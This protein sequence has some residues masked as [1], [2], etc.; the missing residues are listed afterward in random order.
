MDIYQVVAQQVAQARGDLQQAVQQQMNAGFANFRQQHANQAQKLDQ[1]LAQ[2]A[3]I[4]DG[5]K[6]ERSM[7][8]AS[9]DDFRR[10]VVRIED[11]PGRRIPFDYFVDIPIASGDTSFRESS[12]TI[13]MEGPFVAVRRFAVFQSLFQF[14]VS[15][16]AAVPSKFAGRTYGRWR[17][18][19][20][21]FDLN[22]SQQNN[23]ISTANTFPTGAYIANPELTS[24]Q[25]GARSMVFDGRILVINAGSSF[26]R[27]DFSV[28]SPSALWS[29]GY[30][31]LADLGCL[32]FFERGEVITIRVQPT[33]VNNPPAGNADGT[34]IFGAVGWPFLNGQFDK[35]EGIVTPTA[36]TSSSGTLTRLN[37]DSVTRLSDGVLTIGFVGYRIQQPPGI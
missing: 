17:P 21:V 12:I 27:Q 35:H 33:H 31:G 1:K 29:D 14:Q 15:T 10:G 20:S 9:M 7:L 37:P 36:F 32:D 16:G 19:S 18:V 13:S 3:S 23:V 28:P 4:A 11:L 22:D 25:A 8:G 30:G 5:L 24:T 26:P 34:N 6:V 2:L